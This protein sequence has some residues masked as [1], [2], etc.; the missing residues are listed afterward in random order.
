MT[1]SPGNNFSVNIEQK[2]DYER[3]TDNCMK[4][5]ANDNSVLREREREKERERD[6][7]RE[8]EREREREPE[9][10]VN[11]AKRTGVQMYIAMQQ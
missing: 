10:N 7:G 4:L 11:E 5:L 1:P 9:Q 2:T 3:K 6:R 8:R